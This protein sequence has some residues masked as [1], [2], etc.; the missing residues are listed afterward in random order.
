MADFR[1]SGYERR[2]RDF[3]PTPAWVTYA[4]GEKWSLPTEI[5]EPACGEGDMSRALTAMGHKVTSTDIE[6]APD[7]GGKV[8]DFLKDQGIKARAIVTNPPFNLADQFIVRA[9]AVT[10]SERGLVAMLLPTDFDHAKKRVPLFSE[11]P[12]FACKI[13]LTKRIRWFEGRPED[14]GKQPMGNHAWFVW[15][16]KHSGPPVLK[17][18]H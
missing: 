11:H 4:L 5:W 13:V 12:K 7:S 3:Y 16:W 9:L 18:H 2:E 6:P 17:Y 15:D 10:Q 14:K 1:N 8:F